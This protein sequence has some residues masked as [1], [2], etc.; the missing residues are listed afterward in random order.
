MSGARDV[1]CCSAA[2]GAGSLC[3]NSPCARQSDRSASAHQQEC[4]HEGG[5]GATACDPALGGSDVGEQAR[6]LRGW[7]DGLALGV[8]RRFCRRGSQGRVGVGHGG[9]S[10]D[11]QDARFDASSE[12][13]EAREQCGA[14]QVVKVTAVRCCTDLLYT[15]RHEGATIRTLSEPMSSRSRRATQWRPMDGG[16]WRDGGVWAAVTKEVAGR[17]SCATRARRPSPV[18]ST[19]PARHDDRR[20]D[21]S[22]GV[23]R[24]FTRARRTSL[25]LPAPHMN[26]RRERRCRGLPRRSR[27]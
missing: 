23:N 18:S 16:V 13:S 20:C 7:R 21:R 8:A 24:L 5:A 12:Y 14:C 9:P 25:C 26:R 19:C 6:G 15:R 2:A 1:S 10:V 17:R 3:R 4:G 22:C 11:A 27:R